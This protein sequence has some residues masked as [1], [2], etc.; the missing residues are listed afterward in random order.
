MVGVTKLWGLRHFDCIAVLSDQ[1]PL[2]VSRQLLTLFAQEL[3]K[4]SAD[5]H[6]EVAT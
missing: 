6:K 3:S 2:V 1:V 5:A 4:L